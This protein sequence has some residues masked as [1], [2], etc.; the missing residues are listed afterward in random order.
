MSDCMRFSI[1]VHATYILQMYSAK[2]FGSALISSLWVFFQHD[3][4]Q[5]EQERLNWLLCI[6][7]LLSSLNIEVKADLCDCQYTSSNGLFSYASEPVKWKQNQ[8]H[9]ETTRHNVIL[10]PM[11]AKA[12]MNNALA[13]GICDYLEADKH[14]KICST[15]WI[16][17]LHLQ[18]SH[19]KQN[20]K[21]MFAM[22][23]MWLIGNCS[24]GMP[25]SIFPE[26]KVSQQFQG[27]KKLLVKKTNFYFAQSYEVGGFKWNM[28]TTYHVH[29]QEIWDRC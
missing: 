24:L 16:L 4:Q 2:V 1:F 27:Q 6:A 3:N 17:V 10:C 14:P 9:R 7:N 19:L 28:S 5:S 15:T 18:N 21:V 13:V 29:C 8:W 20:D 23:A 12:S 11:D 26:Y 25:M 22:L